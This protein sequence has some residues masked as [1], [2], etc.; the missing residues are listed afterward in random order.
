MNAP[1]SELEKLKR[2]IERTDADLEQAKLDRNELL[3]LMYGNL[4]HDLY[5]KEQRLENSGIVLNLIAVYLHSYYLTLWY[6][7]S[8][9]AFY[10]KTNM[11]SLIGTFIEIKFNCR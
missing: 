10:E 1:L 4:L 7:F 11:G 5:Q 6:H 2:K 9:D 3:V 8:I